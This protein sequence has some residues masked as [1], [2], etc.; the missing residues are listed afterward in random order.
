[1]FT[2]KLG[3]SGIEVSALGMGCWAIGGP[4]TQAGQ[5]EGWGKI[6]DQQSIRAIH[7][8]LDLGITYFDTADA[9]GCGHSERIL[10]QA[11]K[12]KRKQA[13]VATKFGE[14]FNEEK[15]SCLPPV[16]TRSTSARP[17]TP[18]CSAWVLIISTCINSIWAI[19]RW[20]KRLWCGTFWK[21]W[22]LKGKSAITAGAPIPLNAR[23]FLRKVKTAAPSSSA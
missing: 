4:M 13:V 5:P 2:R 8:A 16:P 17:A 7:C 21:H 6:D 18:A 15:K 20:K 22:W 19:I 11:L 9:Y 14:T 1:M 10:G 23:P 12:G 3:K